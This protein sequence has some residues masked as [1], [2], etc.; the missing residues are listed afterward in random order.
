MRVQTSSSS[1]GRRAGSSRYRTRAPTSQVDESLFGTPKPVPSSA[2]M[3]GNP[4]IKTRDQSHSA[5]FRT[6]QPAEMVHIITKD[7]IRD[8][9]VRSKDPSGLSVILSPTEI[10]RITSASRVLTKE[11]REAMMES[12]HRQWETA[13]E[14]AKEKKEQ[15]HQADMSRKKNEALTELEVEARDRAKYLLERANAM[16]MEQEDEIKRLNEMILG[17]QC[18]MVR[19]AQILEK[20]QVQA[21]LAEEEKRL[22]VMMELDRRKAIEAQQQIDELRKQQMIDGKQQ[23]LNQISER[24]EERLQQD[25]LK[26]QERQ[27]VLENLEKMQLEELQALERKMEEQRHLQEEI[28]KINAEMLQ[29]KEQKKEEEK[30]ADIRAM[31]YTQKKM[32]REAEYEAEQRRIKKEK[33]KEVARLRAL[34]ERESDYKAEQD[35]LRARRNQEA[36]E[37]EWRRKEKEQAEKKAQEEAMLKAARLEQVVRK[38]HLLSIEAGRERAEFERLLKEQQKAITKQQ[39]EE[40]RQRE[41]ALHHANAVRQQV[42][43]QEL[44][45]IAK[46]REIFKEKNRLDEEARQTRIRLD[47]IKEKKLRELRAVGLPEKYCNEVERKLHTLAH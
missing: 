28:M 46:R 20:K 40:E 47:E 31:E 11:E 32:E 7:L 39:E 23:I 3:N 37:R 16:K 41:K 14:A 45:A 42:K 21:E 34:Q 12:Q 26:A 35:E 27:E 2:G 9:K 15:I 8:L 29:A 38:E 4:G 10:K 18:H 43:E 22:D 36:A 1:S 33:E 13:M 25:A 19:D 6:S 17:A 24:L 5:P 44:L 30:L